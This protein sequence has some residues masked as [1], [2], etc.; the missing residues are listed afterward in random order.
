MVEAGKE[1]YPEHLDVN[2]GETNAEHNKSAHPRLLG[3]RRRTFSGVLVIVILVIIGGVLGGVLG[4]RA[5]GDSTTAQA[6]R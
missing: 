2:N 6:E 5:K 4:S 3:L 1:V